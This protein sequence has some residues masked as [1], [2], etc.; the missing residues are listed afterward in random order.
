MGRESAR[1]KQ[2][3]AEVQ[4]WI[5]LGDR[6]TG[7]SY[8]PMTHSEAERF[9]A[10]VPGRIALSWEG[11]CSQIETCAAYGLPFKPRATT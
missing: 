11:A 3:A 6:D 5:V 4:D 9:A 10:D 2:I 1:E 7:M 8:G